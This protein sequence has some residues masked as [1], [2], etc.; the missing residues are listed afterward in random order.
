MRTET[1]ELHE[2]IDRL[3]RENRALREPMPCGHPGA[4]LIHSDVMDDFCRMCAADERIAAL[5]AE[6]EQLQVLAE[7]VPEASLLLDLA[8]LLDYVLSRNRKAPSPDRLEAIGRSQVQARALAAR[9]EK[10]Q[11][12][13]T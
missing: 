11:K 13:A 4:C 10:A 3:G 2:M 8:R 5:E 1:A 7:C 12:E 9:I 6:L